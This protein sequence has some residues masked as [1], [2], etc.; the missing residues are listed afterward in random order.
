MCSISNAVASELSESSSDAPGN[1]MPI[2]SDSALFARAPL[3][4]GAP[5]SARAAVFHLAFDDG[6]SLSRLLL[7]PPAGSYG[8][9]IHRA[10]LT[11]LGGFRHL[12]A[13][14]YVD[15]VRRIGPMRITRL[16]TRLH[17][18]DRAVANIAFGSGVRS[19]LGSGLL[20]LRFPTRLVARL[21][22]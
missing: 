9:L 5:A 8:L 2:A 21:F 12:P 19:A 16:R 10:F 20:A 3:V 15:L 7:G 22:A 17:V 1:G 6:R 14:E 18:S 11:K 13:V 4:S